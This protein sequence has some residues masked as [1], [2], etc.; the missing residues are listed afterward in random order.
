MDQ[1]KTFFFAG[2]ETTSTSI[3]WILML[4]AQ[5]PEWADKARDE[6]RTFCGDSPPDLASIANLKVVRFRNP[7]DLVM[8]VLI[9][10][11]PSRVNLWCQ[12]APFTSHSNEK[13]V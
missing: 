7:A 13:V 12:K 5:H 11:G 3:A 4:L 9:E 10:R 6:I 8:L 2:H 1:C